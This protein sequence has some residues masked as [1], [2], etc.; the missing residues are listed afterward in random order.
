MCHL[1]MLPFGCA[2]RNWML[3][4]RANRDFLLDEGHRLSS[5]GMGM[6]RN[7]ERP[8]LRWCCCCHLYF[9]LPWRLHRSCKSDLLRGV[10][11]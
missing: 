7:E 10:T 6:M 1:H 2:S 9:S 4:T 8:G 3:R 5:L 11:K